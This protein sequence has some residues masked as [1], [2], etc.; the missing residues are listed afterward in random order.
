MVSTRER[1]A[2]GR[3]IS[4][5]TV[6]N[7]LQ[8]FAEA[9]LAHAHPSVDGCRW[10]ADTHDHVHVRLTDT[11]ELLDVP[12]ELGEKLLAA[13]PSDVLRSI[14]DELSKHLGITVEGVSVHLTGRRRPSAPAR[15]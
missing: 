15:T 11:N 9:G 13:V 6:Y 1:G 2:G 7:T 4:L 10:D 3:A 8:A 12:D 5:A 14:C